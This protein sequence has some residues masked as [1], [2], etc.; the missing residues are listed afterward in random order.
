MPQRSNLQCNLLSLNDVRKS[1]GTEAQREVLTALL[2]FSFLVKGLLLLARGNLSLHKDLKSSM[3]TRIKYKKHMEW[4]SGEPGILS[5]I[6]KTCYLISIDLCFLICK[7]WEL[8]R[9][10]PG[11]LSLGFCDLWYLIIR[12]WRSY[13]M[14]LHGHMEESQQNFV[15]RIFSLCKSVIIPLSLSASHCSFI[16]KLWINHDARCWR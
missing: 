4:E 12:Y 7:I 15:E 3:K 8:D 5:Q 10:S 13:T 14:E 9:L 16:Q 1:C 6:Q 2:F 11:I